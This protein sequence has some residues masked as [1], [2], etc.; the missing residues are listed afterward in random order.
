MKP[1]AAKE[2]ILKALELNTHEDGGCLI[3]HGRCSCS[4][5]HPKYGDLVMRREVWQMKN[6]PL[7][8]GELVTVTCENKLCLEHL[9]L[10]TKSEAGKKANADPRIIAIKRKRSM[11]FARSSP[12]AKLSMEKARAIRASTENDHAEAKKY[13][14]DHSLISKVRRNKAWVEAETNPFAGLLR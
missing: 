10:T 9:A 12:T 7:K 8:P 3:W 2:R 6:R 14:V 11:L 13:G 1:P 5:G 4:R